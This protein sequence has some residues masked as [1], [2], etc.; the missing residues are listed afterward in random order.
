MRGPQPSHS[1]TTLTSGVCATARVTRATAYRDSK[2]GAGNSG[3]VVQRRRG[4]ERIEGPDT[5]IR[6]QSSLPR[7]A[8][9]DTCV[10]E[11]AASDAPQFCVVA[12]RRHH[13]KAPRS[14]P[15]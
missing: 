9:T 4:R 2:S 7:S 12:V 11:A 10:R 5:R 13:C 8:C 3:C 15:P 14:R 6:W 1:H